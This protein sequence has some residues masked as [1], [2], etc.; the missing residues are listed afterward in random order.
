ML[1]DAQM[2]HVAYGEQ[3]IL[4]FYLFTHLIHGKHSN[5]LLFSSTF[6]VFFFLN[7]K[8]ELH[9][10]RW[11]TGRARIPLLILGKVSSFNASNGIIFNRRKPMEETKAK[12][13]LFLL[14]K[15]KKQL[16]LFFFW[17]K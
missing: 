15:K 12:F 9:Q 7:D 14:K 13:P 1:T 8:N 6:D 17:V 16:C 2:S 3:V 10:H 4:T 5:A 11:S